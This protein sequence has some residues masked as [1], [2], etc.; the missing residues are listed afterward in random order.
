M[1][2]GLATSLDEARRAVSA[3]LVTVGHVPATKAE[4]LVAA[5]VPLAVAVSHD[6]FVSRGGDKLDAALSAFEID[7]SGLRCLDAGASTGG[8]TDRLLWGGAAHV[9]ALDVGYGALAWELR[10]DARVTVLERMNVRAL[11]PADL[12]YA[13]ELVTAD[14]SFISLRSVLDA[15]VLVSSPLASFVLLVK[16][17]F[18]AGRTEVG[19]GG[20]VRDA[21]VW[22]RVLAEVIAAAEGCGLGP[23][24]AIPSPIR[25]P[26]GNV[27][28][29]LH[30]RR[31]A[32]PLALDL[33]AVVAAGEAI[34]G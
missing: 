1:R 8:F 29:L 13:P 33:A 18:E 25:G 15:L 19:R 6:G 34:A 16:P 22:R 7:P 12:P 20:V 27:E 24:G 17:Q 23:L 10:T 28:F 4:T 31:G 2:R 30:L 3:G 11:S 26:A 9:V 14:L 5:D 21:A 32:Q